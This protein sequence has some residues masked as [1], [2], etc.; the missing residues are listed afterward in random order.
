MEVRHRLI[1]TQDRFA[2][3]RISAHQPSRVRR[4]RVRIH[5]L[6]IRRQ[7]Q[8]TGASRRWPSATTP[9]VEPSDRGFEDGVRRTRRQLD[10]LPGNLANATDTPRQ[11]PGVIGQ[12]DRRAN[13]FQR[14]AALPEQREIGQRVHHHA[15]AQTHQ[16]A[17]GGRP[18]IRLPDQVFMNG[19]PTG[20]KLRRVVLD[21]SFLHEPD[22]LRTG[23]PLFVRLNHAF[24]QFG[25]GGIESQC[26]R[27][28]GR[29]VEDCANWSER[30]RNPAFTL[31]I[32]ARRR[33]VPLIA[34]HIGVPLVRLVEQ[35]ERLHDPLTGR[36]TEEVRHCWSAVLT[37]RVTNWRSKVL[38]QEGIG[39]TASRDLPSGPRPT[40]QRLNGRLDESR[41][42][43]S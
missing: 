14:L 5:D 2:N 34:G 8:E 30:R 24:P 28:V 38:G 42:A 11:H 29:H 33:V 43:R 1:R 40:G 21:L 7:L 16:I 36:C 20:R 9:P 3:I 6:L 19:E 25:I 39:I 18:V 23:I 4:L 27:R 12:S 17:Q 26:D 35:F 37:D 13:L 31:R 41:I 32:V 15:F 10:A 22:V